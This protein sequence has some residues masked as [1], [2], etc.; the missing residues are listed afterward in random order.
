MGFDINIINTGSSGNCV[1]IDGTIAIDCGLTAK[2]L[3]PLIEDSVE[4][5][6]ITHRHGDHLGLSFLKALYKKRPWILEGQ[7]HINEDTRQFIENSFTA[8]WSF[9]INSNHIITQNDA[10][11]IKTSSGVYRVEAF[12]LY[13]DVE[14]Y[15]FIFTN[16]AG[17]TL[18]YATDTSSLKDAPI[19]KYDY[20]VIE[21]NYDEDK[22]LE[23]VRSEDKDERFRAARNFRHLSVQ[24]F[25]DF[26]RKCRK[27]NTQIY[28]LHES[29]QYGTSSDFG[30]NN[31][32]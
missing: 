19:R 17:E 9:D 2:K 16:E 11:E 18:I 23:S 20:I 26:V 21:G 12:K 1:I 10:F 32:S 3:M 25:E 28:Q 24:A 27:E 29:G 30:L 31:H 8:R 6:I 5:I 7:L 15:G 4:S 13:H 14:N 22:I